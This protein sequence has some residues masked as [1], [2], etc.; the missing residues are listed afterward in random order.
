[1]F[2]KIKRPNYDSEIFQHYQRH[3]GMPSKQVDYDGIK[4]LE[5]PPVDLEEEDWIYATIGMHSI[6]P[7]PTELFIQTRQPSGEVV[8]S[9]GIL[10]HYCHQNK[11]VFGHGHTLR[12]S[13]GFTKESKLTD[14]ILLSPIYDQRISMATIHIG[15]D[16]EISLL[17]VIPLYRQEREFVV[18]T[19]VNDLIALFFDHHVDTSDLTRPPIQSIT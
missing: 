2:K 3:W 10:A 8:A 16:V 4:I 1:M 11:V 14:M 5:F 17:W 9:L 7:K 15:K 6:S 12:G 18:R 19:S 13:S